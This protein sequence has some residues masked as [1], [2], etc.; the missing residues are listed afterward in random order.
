MSIVDRV[1]ESADW[2]YRVTGRKPVEVV[3]GGEDLHDVMLSPAFSPNPIGPKGVGQVGH[4]LGLAVF[5][6][7]KAQGVRTR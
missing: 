5:F 4:I 2:H 6:D 3:V 7:S 1:R